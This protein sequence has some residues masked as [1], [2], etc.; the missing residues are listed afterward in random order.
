[1]GVL[2][3]TR[4]PAV[5]RPEAFVVHCSDPRFQ[6][7]F[8]EFLATHLGLRSYGLIAA[9]GGPQLLRASELLPKFAWVGWRWTKFLM[10]LTR[11]PRLIL[12]GHDGC[13]WYTEGPLGTGRGDPRERVI[14][15]LRKV[16]EELGERF[17]AASVEL[18]FARLDG[19]SAAFETV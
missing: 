9:P 4:H 17:P 19:E 13:R 16:R 7:H 12:I 10:N 5:E 15:D 6:G 8:H 14:A 1:M 18:Y 3:R 2:Y 11:P